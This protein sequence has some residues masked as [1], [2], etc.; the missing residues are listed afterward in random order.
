MGSTV[1]NK[2][3]IREET[4]RFNSRNA[5]YHGVQSRLHV[6]YLKVKV[7]LSCA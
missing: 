6:V 5:Y 3:Y 4:S 2:N 1:A 7:K